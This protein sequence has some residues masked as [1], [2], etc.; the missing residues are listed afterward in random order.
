MRKSKCRKCKNLPEGEVFKGHVHEEPVVE[1][2]ETQDNSNYRKHF[3]REL[4]IAESQLKEGDNLAIKD[5]IPDIYSIIEKFG[6]QGHSGMSAPFYAGALSGAIKKA[7]LFGILSPLT[8]NDDE[9]NDTGETLNKGKKNDMFQN[10]RISAVF[11]DG[12]D[13]KAYYLDAIVWSGEEE[14]DT[15]TGCVEG[16]DSRQFI[17]EFPFTPKTFYVDVYKD[18]KDSLSKD[19]YVYRLKDPKQLDEVYAYYQ[20]PCTCVKGDSCS[21]CTK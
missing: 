14:H 11:K 12:K 3:D 6:K 4:S 19:D 9:W 15:F 1:A 16:V 10:N 5:F 7:L 17:R 13:G 2:V 8:G 18:F 20:H 21:N